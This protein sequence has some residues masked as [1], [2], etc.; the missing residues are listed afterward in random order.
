[1]CAST[2]FPTIRKV[3]KH[4]AKSDEAN[5]LRPDRDY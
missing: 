1:M 5:R 2:Y 4:Q 3:S